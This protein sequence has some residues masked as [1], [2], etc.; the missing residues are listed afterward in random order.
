MKLIAKKIATHVTVIH[1]VI[2]LNPFGTA[3]HVIPSVI[4]F[5]PISPPQ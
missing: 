2:G 5:K 4:D 1:H 3:S